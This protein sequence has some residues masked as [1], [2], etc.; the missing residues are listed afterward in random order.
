LEKPEEAR[1]L[2]DAGQALIRREHSLDVVMPMLLDLWARAMGVDRE[3]FEGP[4]A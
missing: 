4:T 1:R 3:A 2:G